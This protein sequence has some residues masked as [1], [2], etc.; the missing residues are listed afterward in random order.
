MINLD[1]QN[2]LRERY[3]RQQPGWR[4]ATEVYAD[5][6]RSTLVPGQRV[7]DLGCGRGGLIEQLPWK[8][9]RVVGLD[10]DLVSL[11]EHRLAEAEIPLTRAAAR[12]EMLPIASSSQDTILASWVVEHLPHPARSLAEVG[13]TL[14]PGGSFLFITPNKRHPLVVLFWLASRLTALQKI[15]VKSLYGRE[16]ADTFP[17]YYRANTPEA[18]EQLARSAGME[19]SYLEPVADPTYL[20]IR[21]GLLPLVSRVDAS[22]GRSRQIHLVGQMIRTQPPAEDSSA[23]IP[24]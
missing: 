8:E 1:E 23:S 11:R 10:S 12:T 2:A 9:M 16:P 24:I 20:A 22:L 15:I 14:K 21:P 4:P 19:L 7:L 18:L 13:R 6:A 3:R 5:L 17:A